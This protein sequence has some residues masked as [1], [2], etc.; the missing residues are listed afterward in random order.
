MYSAR[1]TLA[2]GFPHS[3]ISGSMSVC[4]LPGAFR[5]LPRPSSPVI[6][7][8]STTCTSS[9]DPIA[10]QP[11]L[12][13]RAIGVDSPSLAAVECACASSIPQ[14]NHCQ[15]IDD[16]ISFT[17]TSVLENAVARLCPCEQN[18]ASPPRDRR[19]H[20]F[21]IVKELRLSTTIRHNTLRRML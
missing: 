20:T 4:R 21:R 3:D 11:N 17:Q 10:M 16:A 13:H 19:L 14:P 5:R 9:L 6:A 12:G 2:G 15:R 18:H 7:K 1:A 8:A